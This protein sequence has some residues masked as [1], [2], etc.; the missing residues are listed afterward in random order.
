ME[1]LQPFFIVGQL[2]GAYFLQCGKSVMCQEGI[3]LREV[4][5]L[6]DENARTETPSLGL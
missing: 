3:I 5:Y 1:R 2:I 6:Q 4:A